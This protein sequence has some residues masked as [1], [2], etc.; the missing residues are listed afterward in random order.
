MKAIFSL[1]LDWK[2]KL[3]IILVLLSSLY[4]WHVST[5]KI[6]VNKAVIEIKSESLKQNLVLQGKSLKS[7]LELQSKFD[8]IQKDKDAKIKNLDYRVAS[9]SDSLRKRPNRPE[10]GRVPGNPRVEESEAGATGAQLYR[11]D[12][13]FLTGEA[14]RAELIRVE[15]LGCYRSYDDV[16][17]KLDDFKRN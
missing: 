16:K 13:E 1:F 7:Q 6:A 4:F 10:A 8:N 9:L 3:C 14:S 11:Q 15:L 17:K 2:V 12:G 5:L